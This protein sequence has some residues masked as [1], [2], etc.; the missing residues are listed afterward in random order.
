[1]DIVNESGQE[2]DR[3]DE[4]EEQKIKITGREEHEK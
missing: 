1:M 3:E 4:A 2:R